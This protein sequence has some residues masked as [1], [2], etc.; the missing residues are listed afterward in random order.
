MIEMDQYE[1]VGSAV[2]VH[3]KKIRKVA[4]ET[5]HSECVNNSRNLH[6]MPIKRTG[7]SPV[8]FS[9][10]ACVHYPRRIRMEKKMRT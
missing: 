4:R 8:F 5:G 10:I 6:A 7:E 3:G 9:G 1:Y 2:R